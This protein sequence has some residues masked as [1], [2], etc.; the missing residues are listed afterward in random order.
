[1][2]SSGRVDTV[3]HTRQSFSHP[4]FE[5]HAARA[6]KMP[7]QPTLRRRWTLGTAL[8]LSH[9]TLVFA[10]LVTVALGAISLRR[11]DHYLR[12]L[13][14]DE[15]GA[16]DEQQTL[17]R[18]MWAVEVAMRHA[19]EACARGSPEE[20]VRPQLAAALQALREK[21]QHVGPHVGLEMRRM[22]LRYEALA[23]AVLDDRPCD[24]LRPPSMRSAR[25]ALDERLT[26]LWI[27]QS[28]ELH[29][30]IGDREFRARTTGKRSLVFGAILAMLVSVMVALL[31]RWLSRSISRPLARIARDAT[32]LGH[33]D[34]SPIEPV[35]G[36]AE[37]AELADDL[38]RMRHALAALDSLKQGFVASVS[39]ELRTPLAKIREALSLLEDGTAGA[40]TD[41]QRTLV[42]IASRACE[43]Q[44][45]LVTNLLDLSR[46]RS[47]SLVRM[48]AEGPLTTVIQDAVEAEREDATARGV[49]ISV[50]L[51]AAPMIR[52]MDPTLV[53]R[54][55]ANLLRN[56]VQA[57]PNGSTVKVIATCEGA[58]PP[59]LTAPS[60]AAMRWAKIRFED[61]G[62]GVVTEL[63]DTLFEPFV[64]TR[65]ATSGRAGIGLGLA[66]TREVAR[67]HGGDALLV[68]TPPGQSGA[69]FEL[70]IPIEDAARTNESD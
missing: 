12:E 68:E 18:T 2:L 6:A 8:A 23:Q 28:F 36:P 60:K 53:E 57:S 7:S 40:L 33:G 46:L 25:L 11:I 64:T 35:E 20:A 43:S 16:I 31:A 55:I 10:L 15:L 13:R 51:S 37:V 61:A 42:S 39:H 38:E 44:I 30:E 41:R 49:T 59:A 32:R 52:M 19:D 62:P 1:M 24:A 45:S 14:D 27:A 29:R 56:A 63:R 70:W 58:P 65:P 50:S 67:A 21:D 3:G 26:D 54:A 17:H 47:G 69:R 48:H 9:G 5:R 34:F 66:L 22:G 4:R